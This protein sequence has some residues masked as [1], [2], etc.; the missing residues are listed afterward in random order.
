[1]S[2]NN[3]IIK[4]I[5][6]IS[7]QANVLT[8]PR[9]YIQ[10]TKSHR[11]AL[12]LSQCVYWS[13]RTRDHEE[14][15][16]KS[17]HEWHDELGLN[18]H[19]IETCVKTL[20]DGGWLETK[21][22]KVGIRSTRFYRPNLEKIAEAIQSTLADSAIVETAKVPKRKTLRS[23]IDTETTI[24]NV[25]QHNPMFDVL[26][27]V[28]GSD[29]KAAGGYIGKTAADLKDYD[30][31]L[32]KKWYSPIGWWYVVRCKGLENPQRPSLA[33]IAKTIALAAEYERGG[34]RKPIKL[35]NVVT[36]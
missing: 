11:A 5:K 17:Y 27:E 21:L 31:V 1:M 7:G 19:A 15:F 14:W 36:A 6:A 30:P 26:V 13:D 23:S 34:G 3:E 28:T 2:N 10:F 12:M 29:P 9:V 20:T 25:R 4:L 8:I 22:D 33:S 18:Q 16:Y 35:F 32:V 24:H